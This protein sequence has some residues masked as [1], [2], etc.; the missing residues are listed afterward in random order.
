[1]ES[2]EDCVWL[3]LQNRKNIYKEVS[4]IFNS[5]DINLWNC[6]GINFYISKLNIHGNM[7][8]SIDSKFFYFKTI[9]RHH[10][11]IS[12]WIVLCINKKSCVIIYPA[13]VKNKR[14]KKTK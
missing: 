4:N 2:V 3:M 10:L 14:K 5:R 6:L 7:Y 1:M 12:M 9:T 8:P 13:H 11:K